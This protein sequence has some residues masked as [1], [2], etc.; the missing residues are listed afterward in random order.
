[1]RVFGTSALVVHEQCWNEYP[2]TRSVYRA[3]ASTPAFVLVVDSLYLQDPGTTDN[4]F[5]LSE[6]DLQ[7]RTV[8]YIDIAAAHAD[9]PDEDPGRVASKQARRG[10]LAPDWVRTQHPLMCSY[11]LVRVHFPRWAGLQSTVEGLVM[12]TLLEQY[13]L[14][15]RLAYVWMDHWFSLSVDDVVRPGAA[16]GGDAPPMAALP[17]VLVRGAGPRRRS[18]LL[19]WIHPRL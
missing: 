1:M 16:E 6:D 3:P 19:K 2:H 10:P 11:K 18:A 7:L 9:L 5:H 15:H 17:G 14:Y 12:D 13:R 8:Q 4:A